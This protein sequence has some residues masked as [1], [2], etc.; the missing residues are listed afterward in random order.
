MD[1]LERWRKD[2]EELG[3]AMAQAAA[4]HSK[5]ADIILKMAAAVEENASPDPAAQAV[6]EAYASP[7]VIAPAPLPVYA[8]KMRTT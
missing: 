6:H 4:W 8:P 5:A 1:T 7:E 2:M 3:S